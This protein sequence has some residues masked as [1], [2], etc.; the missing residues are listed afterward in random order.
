M[1]GSVQGPTLRFEIPSR[2]VGNG[3]EALPEC[4]QWT[5]CHPTGPREVGR[6]SRMVGHGRMTLS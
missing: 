4:R 3:R 6:T 1:V 5:G 2:T